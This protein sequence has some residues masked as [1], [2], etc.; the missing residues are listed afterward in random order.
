[1]NNVLCYT[2]SNNL[3]KLAHTMI[4]NVVNTWPKQQLI[5]IDATAGNGHDTLF[6]TQLAKKNDLIL[7]F[8]IQQKALENTQNRLIQTSSKARVMY[9]F[10]SHHTMYTTYIDVIQQYKINTNYCAVIMFNLGYLP[11]SNK[12][13]ITQARTTIQALNCALKLLAIGGIISIHCYTGH[14]GGSEETTAVLTWIQKLSLAI[15]SISIYKQHIKK[16]E[17]LLLIQRIK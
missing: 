6:L 15:W 3:D 9:I 17:Q 10:S 2:T 4:A 5:F 12:Q 16:N 7:T 8:D 1:M 14:I 11:R 13:I